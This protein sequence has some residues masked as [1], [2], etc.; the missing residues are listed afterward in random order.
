VF[1][2]KFQNKGSSAYKDIQGVKQFSVFKNKILCY[3]NGS[4][5]YGSVLDEN[6]FDFLNK[7]G[8]NVC[9]RFENGTYQL[10]DNNNLLICKV[11][12]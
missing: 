4:I 1:L 11:Y 5:L 6:I 7:D 3:N 10:T 12:K 2:K 8:F 9:R